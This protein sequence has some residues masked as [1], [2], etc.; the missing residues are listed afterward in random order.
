M[1]NK[2][3]TL[4]VEAGHCD[5]YI[6]NHYSESESLCIS[7]TDCVLLF[8]LFLTILFKRTYGQS[9]KFKSMLNLAGFQFSQLGTINSL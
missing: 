5:T 3:F 2:N 6:S 1:I 4:W 7:L 9:L 8:A